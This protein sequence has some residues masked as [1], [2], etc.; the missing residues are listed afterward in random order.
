[1][2]S[3]RGDALPKRRSGLPHDSFCSWVSYVPSC[4]CLAKVFGRSSCLSF[5]TKPQHV[6]IRGSPAFSCDDYGMLLVLNLL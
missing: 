5:Q 4:I 3:S 2:A 6:A 1:M